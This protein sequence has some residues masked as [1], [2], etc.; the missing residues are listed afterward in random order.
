[1]AISKGT[2]IDNKYTVTRL[3]KT[4]AVAQAALVQSRE[5]PSGTEFVLRLSAGDRDTRLRQE[6]NILR[7]LSYLDESGKANGPAPEAAT[8]VAD[9]TYEGAYYLI[10]EYIP[11][12]YT[13]VT[14]AWERGLGESWMVPV[15]RAFVQFLSKIHKQDIE[16]YDVKLDHLYWNDAGSPQLRVIDFNLCKSHS[17]GEPSTWQ[18]EDLRRT[19]ILLAQ[20]LQKSQNLPECRYPLP[21]PPDWPT[22]LDVQ[23]LPASVFES[24]QAVI[25]WLHDGFYTDASA[26]VDDL[27]SVE[28]ELGG[29]GPERLAEAIRRRREQADQYVKQ[30]RDRI[31]DGDYDPA[32]QYL[33]RA[34]ACLPFKRVGADQTDDPLAS[35]VYLHVLWLRYI[36]EDE[37]IADSFRCWLDGQ[38]DN[39]LDK[40]IGYGHKDAPIALAWLKKRRAIDDRQQAHWNKIMGLS[41][42]SRGRA[43]YR[44]TPIRQ[45][46]DSPRG[47]GTNA[48]IEL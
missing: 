20:M 29:Q 7:R 22:P 21:L 2:V 37:R 15:C 1:M 4:G 30:A 48:G 36:H 26:A 9:G 17:E 10:T 33:R 14:K 32:W 28:R 31:E 39:A 38:Y 47:P 35:K 44:G 40:L 8:F 19:A 25:A 3:L 46:G 24:T 11:P 6:A 12:E 42:I 41:G 16:Y 18:Q 45:T 27:Q 5:Y 13:T 23:S 43:T 34:W